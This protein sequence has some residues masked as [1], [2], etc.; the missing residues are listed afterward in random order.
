MHIQYSILSI[1][2]IQYVRYVGVETDDITLK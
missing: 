1:Q 2:I